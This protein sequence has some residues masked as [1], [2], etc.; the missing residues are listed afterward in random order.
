MNDN[1]FSVDQSN[2]NPWKITGPE[3]GGK[4]SELTWG[5]QIT[6]PMP[7]E[8]ISE[9]FSMTNKQ[10][11]LPNPANTLLPSKI[12][13]LFNNMVWVTPEF[14]QS[15][16]NGISQ[17]DVD[18]RTLGFFSLILS[19]AKNARTMDEDESVNKLTTIMPRTEFTTIYGQVK[20]Q[21]PGTGTLYDLV[22]I[23]ACYKN[24]GTTGNVV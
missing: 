17:A 6:A 7:L 8:A 11:S 1:S 13:P 10:S 5:P 3:S 19:Y 2:C 20:P 4:A 15:S 23:L 22:K 9:I 21:L 12:H 24:D 18:Q 16:P 14:F